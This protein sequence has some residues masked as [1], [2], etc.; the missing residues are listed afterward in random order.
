MDVLERVDAPGFIRMVILSER[1]IP[2]RQGLRMLPN[3]EEAVAQ[4]N[5]A[6][7]SL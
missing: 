7:A 2:L 4:M 6:L 5:A 1:N 3:Y